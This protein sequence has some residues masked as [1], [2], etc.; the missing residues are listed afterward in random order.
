[1]LPGFS[2]GSELGEFIA[3]QGRR[4]RRLL[5]LRSTGGGLLRQ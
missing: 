3:V 5:N 1:V 2:N 4:R